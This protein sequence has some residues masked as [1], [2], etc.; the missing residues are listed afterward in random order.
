MSHPILGAYQ[1]Q[2]RCQGRGQAEN[3]GR[4]WLQDKVELTEARRVPALSG[5]GQR[6]RTQKSTTY[7]REIPNN[8]EKL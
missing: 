1:T 3:V 5:R 2:L 7:G 8:M 6:W 4:G